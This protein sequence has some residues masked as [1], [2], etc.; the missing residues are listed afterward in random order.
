M[1]INHN[2]TLWTKISTSFVIAVIVIAYIVLSFFVVQNDRIYRDMITEI[3][4]DVKANETRF[5]S[6]QEDLKEI[7]LLLR[8]TAPYERKE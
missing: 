3:K 8:R 6:I 1:E 2:G 4:V 7:K 5:V